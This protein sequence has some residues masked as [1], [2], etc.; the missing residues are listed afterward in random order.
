MILGPPTQG[1]AY[2][3]LVEAELVAELAGGPGVG[4]AKLINVGLRL[5]WEQSV[6]FI[7]LVISGVDVPLQT[8]YLKASGIHNIKSG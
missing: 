3:K 8:L 7:Y 6:W 2:Q 1:K 5:E 4:D